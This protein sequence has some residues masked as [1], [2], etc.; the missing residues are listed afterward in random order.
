[1]AFQQHTQVLKHFYISNMEVECSQHL[2]TVNHYITHS[3]I[4][5]PPYPNLPKI[6]PYL[7]MCNISLRL[8]PYAFPQH[9]KMLKHFLYIQYGSGK[10]SAVVYNPNH[11]TLR[12]HVGSAIPKFLT[13]DVKINL[14]LTLTCVTA[15]GSPTAYEMWMYSNLYKFNMEVESNQW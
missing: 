5:A 13:S 14:T 8:Y 7:D 1:M 2:F 4:W 3:T 9:M 12:H 15:Q 10:R 6:D 11:N